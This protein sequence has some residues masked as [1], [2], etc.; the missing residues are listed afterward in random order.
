MKKSLLSLVIPVFIIAFVACT[1]KQETAESN[2]SAEAASAESW[3]MMDEFHIVMAESFHPYKD[4]A[5]IGPA[6]ELAQE[7]ADLA[8]KWSSSELPPK[9]DTE[10]VKSDLQLLKT[11]TAEFAELVKTGD[12]AQIGAALKDLH[13]LFHR[14]QDEWYHGNDH[15][16][17]H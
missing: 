6:L 17:K 5:N 12:E 1:S 9:V 10:S 3:P 16:H 8:D 14:L 11:E 2:E 4:S 13:D 7:M 15:G